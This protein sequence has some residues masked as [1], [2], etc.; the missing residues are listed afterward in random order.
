MITLF[1][2][3]FHWDAFFSMRH[4]TEKTFF[5]FS[6]K[7][8]LSTSVVHSSTLVLEEKKTAVEKCDFNEDNKCSHLE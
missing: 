3:R 6:Y 2:L 5:F 1:I 8:L 4:D 7:H